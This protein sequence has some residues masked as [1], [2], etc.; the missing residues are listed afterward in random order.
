MARKEIDKTKSATFNEGAINDNFKELYEGAGGGGG[1]GISLDDLKA[2][3]T[4]GEYGTSV[5]I[6]ESYKIESVPSRLIRD[7]NTIRFIKDV[8]DNKINVSIN[9]GHE[10]NMVIHDGKAYIVYDYSETATGEVW[11]L[12]SGKTLDTATDAE[13]KRLLR[14]R[15]SIVNLAT[16]QIISHVMIA[17]PKDVVNYEGDDHKIIACGNPNIAYMGNNIMRITIDGAAGCIA[18]RDYNISTGELGTITPCTFTGSIRSTASSPVVLTLANYITHFVDNSTTIQM[19]SQYAK[20]GSK[21]YILI[22]SG[23]AGSICPIFTTEDFKTFTYWDKP[24]TRVKTGGTDNNPV[25]TRADMTGLGYEMALFPW[26]NNAGESKVRLV[27]AMRGTANAQPMKVGA[28]SSGVNYSV[29]GNSVTFSENGDE[30]GVIELYAEIPVDQNRPHFFAPVAGAND[31]ANAVKQGAI[32]LMYGCP[33][34]E[35]NYREFMNVLAFSGNNSFVPSTMRVVAQGLRMTYTTISYYN[36]WYYVAYQ[37]HGQPHVYLSK[38]KPFSANWDKV[39][40]ALGRMFDIF[41]P[42]NNT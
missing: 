2:E 37:G 23:D 16:M 38:F 14:T 22:G 42:K 40:S 31:A 15:L 4:E 35:F 13:L 26:R 24:H 18:Y 19:H 6:G 8:N 11:N 27:F 3:V 21:Y 1:G 17:Q 30:K 10:P 32:Y 39:I 28:I 36:G 20:I 12:P 34:Q 7:V 33:G 25:Y 9:Y 29:S 5:V 41:E